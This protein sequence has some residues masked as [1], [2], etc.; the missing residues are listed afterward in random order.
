MKIVKWQTKEN[1]QICKNHT[2]LMKMRITKAK[3]PSVE[4][5]S[6]I[7]IVSWFGANSRR[8]VVTEN[9]LKM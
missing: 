5:E 6:F 2:F 3:K 9:K 8:S 1:G 4:K 7:K